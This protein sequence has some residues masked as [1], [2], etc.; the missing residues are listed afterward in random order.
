MEN[1]HNIDHVAF[2]NKLQYCSDRVAFALDMNWHEDQKILD[3]LNPYLLRSE[4]KRSYP[5][6]SGR[7]NVK[8]CS[9]KM[10]RGV[11]DIFKEYQS[12][13][14]TG[15]DIIFYRDKEVVLF[16]L[17]HEYCYFVEDAFKKY[18]SEFLVSGPTHI[19]G[20]IEAPIPSFV[21]EDEDESYQ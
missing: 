3:K 8:I 20:D 5:G 14:E 17:F 12:F 13:L 2:L 6:R 7:G 19:L 11:I 1:N 10:C 9:F 4:W 16:V 21:E 15:Y 18:F